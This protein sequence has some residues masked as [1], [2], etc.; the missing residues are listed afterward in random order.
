MSRVY[1]CISF[2]AAEASG[3]NVLKSL[4]ICNKYIPAGATTKIIYYNIPPIINTIIIVFFCEHLPL[5]AT[6]MHLFTP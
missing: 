1:V 2:V 6:M 4:V 3:V 5:G